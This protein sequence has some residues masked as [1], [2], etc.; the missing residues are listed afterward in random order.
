MRVSR[1]CLPIFLVV[2][3]LLLVVLN[4]VTSVNRTETGHLGSAVYFSQTLRY[5]VFHVNPPLTR[6]II[7]IPIR[8]CGPNY[9]DWKTYSPRPQDR[10]EWSLGTAFINANTPEKVRQCLFWA[11][12]SLIPILLLGGVCGYRF[13]RE[14]YGDMAGI[15]FLTLWCFS[16]PVLGWGATICPDAVAAALGITALY[17]FWHW[18]KNPTWKRAILAGLCLGLLP[19]TKMTWI[20]AFPIWVLIWLAWVLPSRF[21]RR[22]RSAVDMALPGF[23]QLAVTLLIGLY[24]I[25]AGYMF[26][27]SFR[28]LKS[29]H[30]ISNA[31]T[32]NLPREG[33]FKAEQ[34][35]RFQDNRFAD[36]WLGQ[37]PVPLPREFVLGI[38]TQKLDFERGLESYFRGEYSQ[39]GWWFYYPYTVLIRE[40]LGNLCLGLL[41]LWLSIFS[42]KDNGNRR[43]EITI[44][45][46]PVVLFAF[47]CAQ[48]GFSLHPRYLMPV[49]PFVYLWMAKSGRVF[50]QRRY[51][52]STVVSLLLLWTVASSLWQFPHSMSYFNELIG[53]PKNGPKHLMGSNVDWGQN[54]YFLKHWYDRHPEARPIR[55]AYA[56]VESFERLGIEGNEPPP[57]E[58]EPGWFAVGVHELYSASGQYEYFFHFK[59]VDRI[60]DSIDIYHLTPDDVKRYSTAPNRE[61]EK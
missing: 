13:A 50:A 42:R 37:I 54:A 34:G 10:S 22:T 16:P 41:A 53:G 15:V 51:V 21:T 27:G 33:E 52:L 44:L 55:I 40:P 32:G 5:D 23:K 43:N 28:T 6:M 11:R 39:H 2:Q 47:I 12:C 18:L 58:P 3:T 19:L 9:E 20:L 7:G 14:L 24:L 4:Y 45:I 1:F 60:G 29:Y 17:A 36:S 59:P 26:D 49:L 48:T 31:L 25:N 56:S 35:D 57:S 61:D 46:P 30:F 8:L 38:D